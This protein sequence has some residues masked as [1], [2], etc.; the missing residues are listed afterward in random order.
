M[1]GKIGKRGVDICP[2]V[3][4]QGIQEFSKMDR[5]PIGPQSNSTLAQ[6]QGRIRN[7]QIRI[8]FTCYTQTITFWAGALG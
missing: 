6:R 1:V 2:V 7:N 5:T 3:S 4:G 8:K